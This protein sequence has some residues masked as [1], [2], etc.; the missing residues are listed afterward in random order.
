MDQRYLLAPT[1]QFYFCGM[2]LRLDASYRCDMNCSYCFSNLRCGSRFKAN[3]LLDFNTIKKYVEGKRKGVFNEFN[4]V[5]MPIHFG[6]MS[7]PFSNAVSSNTSI[8]VLKYLCK[9]EYPVIVSTKNPKSLLQMN[10]TNKMKQYIV[11]Q[12]SFSCINQKIANLIEPNSPTV[13][14]RMNSIYELTKKGIRVTARIQPYIYSLSNEVFN[15]LIPR[16]IECGVDHIILEHL[17]IPI[18]RNSALYLN[19]QFKMAGIDLALYNNYGVK[20]G[21][22]II[23]PNDKKIE[24]INKMKKICEDYHISFGAADTG[25]YHFSTTACCCGTDKYFPNSTWFNGNFTNIIKDSN[26]DYLTIDLL[27]K[28]FYP[29]SK[30][31]MYIN[32]HSRIGDN[33][34]KELLKSKWNNPGSENAMDSYYGIELCNQKDKN[35]NC[36]YINNL[37]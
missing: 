31:S 27:D 2:P 14:D 37:K 36:I 16:L 15:E 12:V 19:T 17:K 11:V 34:F 9:N 1:S 10:L 32:S 18:E 25:F 5:K 28:Y 3:N 8:D 23:L 35:G 6:G 29:E 30:I 7:D 4:N 20:S 21:R 33:T 13:S 22:E 26:D 24:T